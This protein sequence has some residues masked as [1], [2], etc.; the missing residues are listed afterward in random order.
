M[1]PQKKLKI[2]IP[3]KYITA[4]N[5]KVFKVKNTIIIE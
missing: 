5:S 1:T 4:F 2:Y 3:L